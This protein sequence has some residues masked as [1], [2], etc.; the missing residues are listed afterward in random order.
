MNIDRPR[1]STMCAGIRLMLTWPP[2]AG[3]SSA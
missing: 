3:S 2:G 1:I